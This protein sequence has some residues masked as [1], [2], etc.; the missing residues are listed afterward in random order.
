M[1]LLSGCA[2]TA[3]SP[4]AAPAQSGSLLTEHGLDGLDARAAIERLDT[5]PLAERPNDLFASVQS[6]ALVFSDGQGAE[7]SLPM[8]EDELYVSI[9]P[10]V[11]Q[12]HDCY[13]HSLTTC[14]GELQNQQLQVLVLDDVSGDVLIDDTI[15]SYDNGFFGIWLPR[16]ITATI[17]IGYEGLSA[18]STIATAAE[19]P[20]CVT[21]LQL[22]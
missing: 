1:T 18:T 15:A 8:P 10:F 5:M 13:F 17:T 7:T 14:E 16:D 19:D 20:T 12:T 3:P 21:T 11:D 22:R 2:A 4:A 6:A 9:A